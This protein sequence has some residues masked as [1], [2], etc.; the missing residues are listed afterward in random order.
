MLLQFTPATQATVIRDT[1]KGQ[2][3]TRS[4]LSSLKRVMRPHNPRATPLM[5]SCRP[6]YLVSR[7]TVP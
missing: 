3:D 4:S 2:Q 7:H 5:R 1:G 6:D